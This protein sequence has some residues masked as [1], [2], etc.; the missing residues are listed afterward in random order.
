M[1][2]TSFSRQIQ[3]WRWPPRFCFLV[4]QS[5]ANLGA[6]AKGFPRCNYYPKLVDLK[7]D[8]DVTWWGSSQAGKF[9]KSRVFSIWVQKRK[10]VSKHEKDLTHHWWLEDVEGIAQVKECGQPLAAESSPWLTA[11][12]EMGTSILQP[13]GTNFCYQL[14]WYEKK[15]LPNLQLRA[16]SR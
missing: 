6:S 8:K 14:G 10:S 11:Q 7:V 3:I 1:L 13:L 12:K 15:I 4:I 9:F 5:D 16:L 2:C